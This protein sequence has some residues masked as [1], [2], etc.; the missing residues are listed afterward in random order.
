MPKYWISLGIIC[1]VLTVRC[2]TKDLKVY[3]Y[4]DVPITNASNLIVHIVYNKELFPKSELMI[5][6]AQETYAGKL[7]EDAAYYYR[8][9]KDFPLSFGQNK[10]EIEVTN[11]QYNNKKLLE[12]TR[13]NGMQLES[14]FAD[15]RKKSECPA[16][17]HLIDETSWEEPRSGYKK[18]ADIRKH[19]V[20]ANLFDSRNSACRETLL[21]FSRGRT[22]VGDVHYVI[23]FNDWIKGKAINGELQFARNIIA[24]WQYLD[25]NKWEQLSEDPYGV[26]NW[27]R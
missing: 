23:F 1:L 20:F 13:L 8:Y 26:G 17:Y 6:N 15:F 19:F 12:I 25:I 11:S 27:P 16:S 3:S 5:N 22:L 14:Y 2:G 21:A 24:T 4:P 18:T 10:I 7:I 9:Q